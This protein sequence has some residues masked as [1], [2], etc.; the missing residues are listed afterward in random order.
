[1]SKVVEVRFE[2]GT[3]SEYVLY[4][5]AGGS[6]GVLMYEYNADKELLDIKKASKIRVLKHANDKVGNLKLAKTMLDAFWENER[7]E[8]TQ[9]IIDKFGMRFVRM[10]EYRTLTKW[11]G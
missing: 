11:W 8:N 9:C 5:Y 3:S 6:Y 1:M 10:D 2:D 7:R 4:E